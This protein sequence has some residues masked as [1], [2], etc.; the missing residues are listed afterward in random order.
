MLG[1]KWDDVDLKRGTL[2]VRRTLSAAKS[3]PT[4]TSP[5]NNKSRSV[6]LTAQ[7][8]QA[9]KDHRKRQLEERL[10]YDRLWKDTGLVFTTQIGTPLSRH[11]IFR[12]SFKLLIRRAGLPD[13][14]FH[15]LRH[16]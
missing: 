5:K 10:Q 7:A 2:Q 15:G 11:N 4:F 16:S 13:I 9:L 1:L 12:R 6:R 8:V 14:P 3:G